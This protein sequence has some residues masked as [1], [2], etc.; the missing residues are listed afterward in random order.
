MKRTAIYPGSFDP[1]T[2]GHED[3]AIR[4]SRIFDKLIIAVGVN[5]QKKRLFPQDWMLEKIKDT[6]I[7]YPNIEAVCY[8]ELTI[9]L[10]QKCKANFILRGIR[11]GKDFNFE[12]S[13]AALNK[14]IVET[15]ET[16]FL[17]ATPR[18]VH[19]NSSLVREIYQYGEDI[20]TFIPYNL[21]HQTLISKMKV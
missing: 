2:I 6:F 9:H 17:F 11:D 18:L 12:T 10:A 13:I 3:I 4:G 5:N 1:F 20:K 19:I 15:I 8:D 14:E 7:D 21:K 16:V